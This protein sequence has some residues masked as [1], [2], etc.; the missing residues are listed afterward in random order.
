MRCPLAARPLPF[1]AAS[2]EAVV[3]EAGPVRRAAC[4]IAGMNREEDSASS[5]RHQENHRVANQL[6][7]AAFL[8]VAPSG[9]RYVGHRLD[10]FLPHVP[11]LR[12]VGDHQVIIL[13]RDI[14]RT[15][16]P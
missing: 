10:I 16:V 8:R 6:Y 13:T 12:V 9:V 7:M 15:P 11:E 4:E 3:L 5:S 2:A 14:D 1:K